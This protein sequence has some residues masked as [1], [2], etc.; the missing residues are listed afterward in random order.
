MFFTIKFEFSRFRKNFFCL[1]TFSSQFM[2]LVHSQKY[3][4][5]ISYSLRKFPPPSPQSLKTFERKKLHL[6]ATFI[7]KP[8]ADGFLGHADA[9]PVEPF[10]RALV[11]VARHHVAVTHTPTCAVLAVVALALAV[12]VATVRPIV[13]AFNLAQRALFARIRRRRLKVS[14]RRVSR[15]VAAA[16][17]VAER[18]PGLFSCP[19]ARGFLVAG[20]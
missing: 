5:T 20:V 9:I 18:D 14:S 13:F 16:V 6:S 3:F 8:R 12:V 4:S 10:V 11:V 7:T 17:A 19:S 2:Q 15:G 1:F